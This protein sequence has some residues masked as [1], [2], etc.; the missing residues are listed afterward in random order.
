MEEGSLPGTTSSGTTS[1]QSLWSNAA[2]VAIATTPLYASTRS[3]AP[4]C[5][6]L[7]RLGLGA[8]PHGQDVHAYL[9]HPANSHCEHMAAPS[10]LIL[11]GVAE[12]RAP[13]R[14]RSL[15]QNT[16][17]DG[18]QHALE[19]APAP[20]LQ[21]PQALASNG[22]QM[23]RRTAAAMISWSPGQMLDPSVP[24]HSLLARHQDMQNRYQPGDTCQTKTP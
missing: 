13:W 7:L 19:H 4:P 2:H 16:L 15:N 8:P 3:L 11:P 18:R 6:A 14:M 23:H 20:P 21:R 12:G 5:P 24:S 9:Q 22:G 17:K 10:R 1:Q